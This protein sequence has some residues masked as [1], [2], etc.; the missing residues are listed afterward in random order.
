MGVV[1]DRARAAGAGAMS[2]GRM[3][4]GV[5]V[6]RVVVIA[7]R[8]GGGDATDGSDGSAALTAAA[9]TVGGCWSR[10]SSPIDRGGLK[11][12]LVL[13]PEGAHAPFSSKLG[14][15]VELADVRGVAGV[16]GFFEH[17]DDSALEGDDLALELGLGK[18]W[19]FVSSVSG[20][21]IM[22]EL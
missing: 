12:T 10:K 4:G 17:F 13:V 16:E 20:W 22:K 21:N 3:V 18:H 2:G 14:G 15:V 19:V 5:I 11:H 9:G 7:E 6:G 8:R 1:R